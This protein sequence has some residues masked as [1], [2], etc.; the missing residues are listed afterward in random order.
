MTKTRI[1]NQTFPV[2]PLT[3]YLGV[4]VPQKASIVKV[5]YVDTPSKYFRNNVI[6][7]KHG[8]TINTVNGLDG[9]FRPV[10]HN[11]YY[12]G[13]SSVGGFRTY[14]TA[15]GRWAEGIAGFCLAERVGDLATLLSARPATISD[16]VVQWGARGSDAMNSMLPSLTTGNSLMN[17]IYELKDFKRFGAKL[18]DTYRLCRVALE[19][20]RF[21]DLKGRDIAWELIHNMFG[22][23]PWDR[24]GRKLTS[25][26]LSWQLAWRPFVN[27]VKA[28]LPAILDFNKA[29]REF[30]R[31]EGM[32]EQRYWGVNIPNPFVPQTIQSGTYRHNGVVAAI[33]LDLGCQYRIKETII[34]T[35]RF[36]STMRYSYALS[37]EVIQAAKGLDGLLDRLG[38][39]ANPAILWNAIPFTFVVDWFVNI[40]G[41]LNKLRVNNVRPE[42]EIRDFCS[43]VKVHR[44]LVLECDVGIAANSYSGTVINSPAGLELAY[45]RQT[46]YKRV[47]GIPAVS[48]TIG[49]GINA[50]NTRFYTAASLMHQ[51][52]TKSKR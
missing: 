29:V 35:P 38:V 39:N 34:T 16:G 6:V 13:L 51:T 21:R 10:T 44:D 3:G 28:L 26:W 20:G 30:I 5:L 17:F 40:G 32:D 1:V 46:Y 23:E 47:T 2:R 7:P 9:R 31:R 25:A 48:L 49:A 52:A 8:S 24:P 18:M 12:I 22:S 19:K 27:D 50:S 45:G 36:S 41:Y 43:S 4:N 11:H 42:V 15:E 33:G 14:G 37:A